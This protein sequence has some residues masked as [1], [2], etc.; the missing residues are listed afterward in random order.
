MNMAN[1]MYLDSEYMNEYVLLCSIFSLCVSVCA[2]VCMRASTNR[3]DSIK[4]K[5]YDAI[6]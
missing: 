4:K 2:C 6:Y 1:E 5:L 3:S